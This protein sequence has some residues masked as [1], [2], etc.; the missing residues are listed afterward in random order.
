MVNQPYR[1]VYYLYE[2]KG[3]GGPCHLQVYR[4]VPF[5]R[6]YPFGKLSNEHLSLR[7]YLFRAWFTLISRGHIAIYYTLAEDGTITHTSYLVRKNFKFPFMNSTDYHIGPCF[8]HPDYRGQNIY[9]SVLN[10]IGQCISNESRI[11]MLV[12]PTNKS[13]IQGVIKAGFIHIGEVYKTK[14]KR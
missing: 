1:S 13:S 2:K 10:F 6:K 8:T 14:I 3:G 4:F 9:P 11:F 12:H 7:T 5:S